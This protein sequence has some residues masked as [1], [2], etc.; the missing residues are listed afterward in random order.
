MIY[1]IFYIYIFSEFSQIQELLPF[2]SKIHFLKLLIAILC[3]NIFFD[4]NLTGLLIER[5]KYPQAKLLFLLSLVMVLSVP[6]S[7]YP[8]GSF[9]FLSQYYWKVLI[10]FLLFMAYVPSYSVLKK[11]IY[12]YIFG[13]TAMSL[14]AYLNVDD[15]SGELLSSLDPNEMAAYLCIAFPFAF[16]CGVRGSKLNKLLMAGI[17]LLLVVVVVKTESRGAFVTL[18]FLFLLLLT[19]LRQLFEKFPS[20]FI[21]VVALIGALLFVSNSNSDYISRMTSIIDFENDYNYTSEA[22]RLA[23]WKR[24]VGFIID[25]PLLGVGVNSFITA[26]G[27]SFG[28]QESSVKW[29]AAHNSFLQV[30]TELGVTGLLIYLAIIIS[31]FKNLKRIKS[32]LIA[33]QHYDF[34]CMGNALLCAIF[35]FCIA[36]FFL[37]LAFSSTFIFILALSINYMALDRAENRSVGVVR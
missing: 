37:S 6:F 25:N 36:G 35:S 5:I 23:V 33:R 7:V 15:I 14:F 11:T 3:L 17:C 27:R 32:K 30:G 12:A 20:K 31:S 29:S 19:Y 28:Q 4:R 13:V 10:A 22:G 18:F 8:G 24:G 26:Y 21:L 2:L 16:W 9:A 1:K 34:A